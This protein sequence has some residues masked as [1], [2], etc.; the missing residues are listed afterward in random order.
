M[1]ERTRPRFVV[2]AGFATARAE[3][4]SVHSRL[5]ALLDRQ[6]QPAAIEAW[7]AEA[8]RTLTVSRRQ[9]VVILVVAILGVAIALSAGI[10]ALR[11]HAAVDRARARAEL[12]S[13]QKTEFA[14]ITAHEL[15][16]PLTA[17]LGSLRIMASGRAGQLPPMAAPY[18]DMAS[19]NC[20]RLMELINELLELD[21]ME[22]GML[23][24]ARG[25]VNPSEVVHSACAALDP[26]AE[27][28]GVTIRAEHETTR[29][30]I[31][32]RDR[33]RQVVINLLSNAL[34]HA[35]KGTEVIAR[36]EDRGSQ[37]RISV[38]DRGPGIPAQDRERIFQPFV[39]TGSASDH[40]STGLGL[41]IAREI[42]QRHD[43]QI[44][45]ESELGHGATFW[46]ELPAAD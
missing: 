31:G 21:R 20:A 23:P 1:N 37:V 35:P 4:A 36:L 6:I 11:A 14:S 46:F 40:A 26:I 34:K 33:L 3:Y 42:V 43:G 9:N 32:D 24:F 44:G 18:V 16:S 28:F 8:D 19:R 15:R 30:I 25:A 38:R 29:L 13:Q 41:K 27:E 2:T 39:Q 10:L 22:A 5:A 17:I 45:V 12:T 7:H